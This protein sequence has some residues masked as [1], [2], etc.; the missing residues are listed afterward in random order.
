MD[1]HHLS[2]HRFREMS[3]WMILAATA[4]IVAFALLARASLNLH[5]AL[6]DKPDLAMYILM[7]ET[8]IQKI[9]LLRDHGK[10]RD[11]LVTTATGSLFVKLQKSD[12]K[13]NIIE[14]EPLRADE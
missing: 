3:I 5:A 8:R 10:E 12:G 7:P 13:W 9:D 4:I 11:Y 2:Q 6:T 14:Q 1:I